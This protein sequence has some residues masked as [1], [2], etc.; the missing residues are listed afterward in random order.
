MYCSAWDPEEA[1]ILYSV[2]C[3]LLAADDLKVFASLTDLLGERLNLA[4]CSIWR[5]EQGAPGPER[6]GFYQ[7][8][9]GVILDYL[10]NL[11]YQVAHRVTES[12]EM[13]IENNIGQTAGLKAGPLCPG[14]I[15]LPLEIS[16][17][18]AG[19]LC[20]W[21]AQK[22]GAVAVSLNL[23]R[24]IAGLLAYGL[25]RYESC[26]PRPEDD[27]GASAENEDS[28]LQTATTRP[29]PAIPGA[30][31]DIR[32]LEKNTG[33]GDFFDTVLTKDNNLVL[34]MGT[35]MGPG[36]PVL[37][38]KNGIGLVL[39]MLAA[40]KVEPAKACNELNGLLYDDLHNAGMLLGLL[41]ACY[42]PLTGSL[43]FC[44][45]GYN[46]PVIV[47]DNNDHA[48][49]GGASETFIGHTKSILY[50]EKSLRLKNGAA[51]VFY[52]NGAAELIN[53]EGMHYPRERL[54]QTV[55]KYHY[56]NAHSLLDCLV[57][58]IHQFLG[59]RRLLEQVTLA[60]IKI[61]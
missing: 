61:E 40:K 46:P 16:G 29:R 5:R 30:T 37:T 49:S 33:G 7:H 6:L 1:A 54:E 25:R 10:P 15:A 26:R 9:D 47:G 44:N 48:F 36:N 39:K 20:L 23:A 8:H 50:S 17:K 31:F 55:R 2:S 53:G 59:G 13:L 27:N 52:S 45:A 60:V 57:L 11:D 4:G 34:T 28:S 32:T 35:M 18:A 43:T 22:P 3:S 14:L 12:G 51:V 38:W 24:E 56:F 58:D 19:A 21:V 42:N 41:Y